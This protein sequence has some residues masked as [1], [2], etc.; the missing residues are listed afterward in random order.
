MT[1]TRHEAALVGERESAHEVHQGADPTGYGYRATCS[2]GWTAT[3]A[4]LDSVETA[5][6]AH[7]AALAGQPEPTPNQRQ[8]APNLG[9]GHAGQPEVTEAYDPEADKRPYTELTAFE[10]TASYKRQL[11]AVDRELRWKGTGRGRIESI[12]L[13]ARGNRVLAA[14]PDD[15][16][17]QEEQTVMEIQATVVGALN[18]GDRLALSPLCFYEIT[19]IVPYSGASLLQ[20]REHG[21][22]RFNLRSPCLILA[23]TPQDVLDSDGGRDEDLVRLPAPGERIRCK[24]CGEEI[25][26]GNDG[27]GQPYCSNCD[28]GKDDEHWTVIAERPQ[29]T[30]R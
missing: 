18:V 4:A 10:R 15:T 13:L 25:T 14:L 20:F 2:C 17:A 7:R 21:E 11:D 12:R 27:T 5:G 24:D 3:G 16:S 8:A 23:R 29:E 19:K 6:D 1:D 28:E 22:Q 9:D 26:G 30:E